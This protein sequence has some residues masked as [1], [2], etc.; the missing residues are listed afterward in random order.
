[1]PL[2]HNLL[3]DSTLHHPDDELLAKV[4]WCS[5]ENGLTVPVDDKKSNQ[6][7]PRSNNNEQIIDAT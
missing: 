2:Y 4:G 5:M 3:P 6:G 1:M 7:V